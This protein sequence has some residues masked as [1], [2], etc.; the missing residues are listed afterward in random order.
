[1]THVIQTQFQLA[2]LKKGAESINAYY[3]KA[4]SLSASL[5]AAGNPLSQSQFTVYLLARLGSDY[6]S[7]ISSITTRPEPLSAPQIYSYLLNHESRL[8]HQHQSLLSAS[9][10]SA[11]AAGL[12]FRSPM[13]A[14]QSSRGRTPFRGGRRGRGSGHGSHM[15]QSSNPFSSRSDSRPTCQVCQKVGHTALQCYNRFNQTY[16]SPPPSSF[17]ANF[18]SLPPSGPPSNYWFPDIVAT[19][20]FTSDFANL[21]L[22]SMPYLGPDHVSIGDGSTLPIQNTGSGQ[23]NTGFTNQGGASSGSR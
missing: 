18:T 1:M 2:T 13:A 21:N 12:S 5:S 3:H 15:A 23:L 19:N 20:H 14:G 8:A 4:K 11:N 7:V 6:E 17:R 9:P 16:Q 22:D 10:I